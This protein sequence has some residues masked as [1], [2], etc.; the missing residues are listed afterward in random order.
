MLV[1][2]RTFVDGL[3]IPIYGLSSQMLTMYC[4]PAANQPDN[5]DTL[6]LVRRTHDA[7][8]AEEVRL[9]WQHAVERS[10]G[11]METAKELMCH[12]FRRV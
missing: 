2:I 10:R 1:H 8:G 3:S 5:V 6:P 4:P 7:G 9:G 11:W 12:S